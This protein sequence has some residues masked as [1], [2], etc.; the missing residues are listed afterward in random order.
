MAL[1]TKSPIFSSSEIS[2]DALNLTLSARTFNLADIFTRDP[3][4]AETPTATLLFAEADES[5]IFDFDTN[6][7]AWSVRW[8]A[9]CIILHEVDYLFHDQTPPSPLDPGAKLVN[10]LSS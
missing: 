5:L 10:W 3:S 9:V 4:A 2:K 1:Y 7:S 8:P 6:A